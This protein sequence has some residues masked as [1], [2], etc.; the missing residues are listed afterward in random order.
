[1]FQLQWTR[2][3]DVETDGACA[4]WPP[5]QDVAVHVDL[6]VYMASISAQLSEFRRDLDSNVQRIDAQH[7]QAE[8]ELARLRARLL[9]TMRQLGT[10]KGPPR[11]EGV[12]QAVR[13]G[14]LLQRLDTLEAKV[15]REQSEC[16]SILE[17]VLSTVGEGPSRR[18]RR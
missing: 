15:G 5:H 9:A 18:A 1:M 6:P 13:L 17:V 2:V 8:R 12:K 10:S 14:R 4:A 7:V 11:E 16:I 3:C